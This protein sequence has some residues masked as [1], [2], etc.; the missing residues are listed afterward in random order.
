MRTLLQGIVEHGDARGR[1]LGFPTANLPIHDRPELDGIWAAHAEVEGRGRFQATVSIG[2]RP[3][4]YPDDAMRL[5]EVH[6]LDFSGS[7]YGST[8]S[9]EL[10]GFLRGQQRFSGSEELVARIAADVAATRDLLV[11]LREQ[12]HLPWLGLVPA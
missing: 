7:I 3:T 6:L 8:L 10:V 1:E 2:R 11:P 12:V 4:Y 9:V 5:V